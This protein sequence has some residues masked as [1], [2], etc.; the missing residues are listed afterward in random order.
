MPCG[1]EHSA[2]TSANSNYNPGGNRCQ[3]GKRKRRNALQIGWLYFFLRHLLLE[4][5]PVEDIPFPAALGDLAGEVRG[6][7]PDERVD[8]VLPPP[9]V[10]PDLFRLPARRPPLREAPRR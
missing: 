5:F 10:P 9:I 6:L 1:C 4:I 2:R 7:L 8:L 3:G